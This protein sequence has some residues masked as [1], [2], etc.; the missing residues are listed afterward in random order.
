MKTRWL[1]IHVDPTTKY[2]SVTSK[3]NNGA[4][5]IAILPIRVVLGTGKSANVEFAEVLVRKEVV[6]AWT[7]DEDVNASNSYVAITGLIEPGETPAE[8]A[9]RELLEET[10]YEIPEGEII[11][12][13]WS[14]FQ[15]KKDK[16]R[17]YIFIKRIT[18]LPQKE[19]TGDGTYLESLGSN[20]WI[21]LSR[22]Y[23]PATVDA[24]LMLAY[25]WITAYGE[26]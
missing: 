26:Y 17:H 10:G 4:G 1:D 3:K 12:M 25:N 14:G 23:T 13:I 7:Y 6:P 19:I 9:R 16:D 5:S 11:P 24:S 15:S 18:S 21:R 2:E 20:H 22:L 8:A